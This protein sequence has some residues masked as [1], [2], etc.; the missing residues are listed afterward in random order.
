MKRRL[1]HL[2]TKEEPAV[3]TKCSP[4]TVAFT[5]SNC[6]FLFLPNRTSIVSTWSDTGSSHNLALPSRE[7]LLA[8][9]CPSRLQPHR[10]LTFPLGQLRLLPWLAEELRS[11][12]DQESHSG[13]LSPKA[14]RAI[15]GTRVLANL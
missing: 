8:P 9:L 11:L 14:Q 6:S 2:N 5:G 15:P 10:P 1:Y 3:D 13:I 4:V 7:L 12:V